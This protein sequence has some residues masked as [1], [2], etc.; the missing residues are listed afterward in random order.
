MWVYI[1][2]HKHE[3]FRRFQ[4][5][6]ALVEKSSSRQIKALRSDNVGKYTSHEI[7]SYLTKEGIKHELT[8]PHTPEQNG[9]AE[10]LNRKLIEGV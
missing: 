1:L 7:E 10:R 9:V 4:E 2:K 8:T 5:W 6:K 3:V